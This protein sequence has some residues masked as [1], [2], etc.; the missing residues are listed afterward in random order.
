MWI[1]FLIEKVCVDDFAFKKWYSYG[2][3]MVNLEIH[4]I[5]DIIPSRDTNDVK[6]WLDTF[7][8]LKVISR[9]R[10]HQLALE[11]QKREVDETRELYRQ[12]KASQ[13]H[14]VWT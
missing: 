8:N 9:E 3:V 12:G 5:V 4:K 6:K 14:Y 10:Q 7:P 11:Q 1:S 2:S 13:T